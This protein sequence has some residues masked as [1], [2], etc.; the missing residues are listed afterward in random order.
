MNIQELIRNRGFLTDPKQHTGS[1]LLNASWQSI[2]KLVCVDICIKTKK[3][4]NSCFI[5]WIS[6]LDALFIKP[7]LVLLLEPGTPKGHPLFSLFWGHLQQRLTNV[8]GFVNITGGIWSL[9]G[10]KRSSIISPRGGPGFRGLVQQDSIC[11]GFNCVP[12]SN[13]H[14]LNP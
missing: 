13:I 3:R 10:D 8:L 1:L 2:K 11:Y 5:Q 7:E 9:R 12:P 6:V 4:Q 14:M